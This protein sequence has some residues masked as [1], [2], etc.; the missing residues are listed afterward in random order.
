MHSDRQE[1]VV[2][3]TRVAAVE[4]VR[5]GWILDSLD[6]MTEFAEGLHVGDENKKGVKNDSR[7]FHLSN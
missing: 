5:C 1:V 7:V 4:V 6:R 2:A 3:Q